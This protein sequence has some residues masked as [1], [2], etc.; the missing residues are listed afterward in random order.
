MYYMYSYIKDEHYSIFWVI[1]Y[2]LLRIPIFNNGFS[3]SYLILRKNNINNKNFL[4]T[5]NCLL[6]G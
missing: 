5:T 1:W 3:N 4:I 2:S 6:S